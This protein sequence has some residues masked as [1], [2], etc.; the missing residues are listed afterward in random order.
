MI[1]RS[2]KLLSLQKYISEYLNVVDQYTSVFQHR[3]MI[4]DRIRTQAYK[5]AIG[6]LN[7]SDKIVLDAGCGCGIMSFFAAESGAM[8]IFA[9]DRSNII[10]SAKKICKENHLE[11]KI[12]FLQQDLVH[13]Y[14]KEKVDV[15][16]HETIGLF[17]FNENSIDVVKALRDKQLK[18]G[19]IIL[20]SKVELFF[21][22]VSLDTIG[23]SYPPP[24]FWQKNQY[25]INFSE[26]IRKENYQ[27]MIVFLTT[28]KSF[29]SQPQLGYTLDY[30]SVTKMPSMIDLLFQVKK[31]GLVQGFLG[32]FKIK[33]YK[34]VAINTSPKSKLT[35]WGQMFFPI[36]IPRTVKRGE[37]IR[38]TLKLNSTDYKKWTYQLFS[39]H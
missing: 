19:G 22:L 23:K 3:I 17:L 33:L 7:L 24:D 4:G 20:P 29:L 14:L 12:H 6:K 16:I 10:E 28:K 37:Y 1:G 36:K 32:F 25:G 11:N 5:K 15:I 30:Y 26:F 31:T 2:T 9:V 35:H 8:K 38:L 18:K 13:L 21:T 34:N 27:P 39:T